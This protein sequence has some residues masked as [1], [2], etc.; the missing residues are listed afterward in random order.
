[1]FSILTNNFIDIIN[2]T[3]LA[4]NKCWWQDGYDMWHIVYSMCEYNGYDMCMCVWYYGF[5]VYVWYNGYSL[6]E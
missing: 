2:L 3:I 6:C 1:M 5:D 4:L